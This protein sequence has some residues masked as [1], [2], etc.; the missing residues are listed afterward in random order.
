MKITMAHGSG[1]ESTSKLIESVF[2]K[3]FKNQFLDKLED[4]SVVRGNGRLG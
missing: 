1:G 2:A 4:S 3:H